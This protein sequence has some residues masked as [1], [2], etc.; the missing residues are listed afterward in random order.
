MKKRALRRH[1]LQ[2]IKDLCL[3]QAKVLFPNDREIWHGQML[4]R[5]RNRT[6]CSCPMCGNPRRS[7]LFKAER[8]TRQERFAALRDREQRSEAVH[9][10]RVD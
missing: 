9:G 1:H 5:Y 3:E 4:A 8:V 7:G 10:A 2:R 6:R